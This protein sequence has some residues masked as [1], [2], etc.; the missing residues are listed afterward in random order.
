M[1]ATFFGLVPWSRKTKTINQLY[2]FTQWCVMSYPEY[3]S[4]Q[5]IGHHSLCDVICSSFMRGLLLLCIHLDNRAFWSC[6]NVRHSSMFSLINLIIFLKIFWMSCTLQH[7]RCTRTA[8]RPLCLHWN[9][10]SEKPGPHFIH[11]SYLLS[12]FILFWFQS[13]WN[14]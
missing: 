9:S 10:F 14:L 12:Y 1:D 6:M 8:E 2:R 7:L 11:S 5:S 4:R 3:V 13:L